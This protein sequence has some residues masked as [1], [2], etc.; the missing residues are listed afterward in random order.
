MANNY[1]IDYNDERFTNVEAEKNEQLESINN[2]YN[3][4]IDETD[5]T[6]KGLIDEINQNADKQAELQQQQGDLALEQIENRKEQAQKDYIKQQKGA[7]ADYQRQVAGNDVLMASQGLAHSGYSESSQVSMYNTYQSRVAIAKESIDRTMDD[8]AIQSKDAILQNS[9]ALMQIYSDAAKQKAA[10]TLEAF[11]YK[12]SLISELTN[13]ELAINSE[14]YGRWKDVENQINTENALAE[15]IRQYNEDLAEK[16]RQYNESMAYQKERDKIADEQWQKQYNLTKKSSSGGSGG[17]YGGINKDPEGG[18]KNDKPAEYY[19]SN[20]YQPRYIGEMKEENK[21]TPTGQKYLVN[22]KSQNI[23]QNKGKL[24]VWIGD[25]N[26][27]GYYKQIEGKTN[28]TIAKANNNTSSS[29]TVTNK[30]VLPWEE[31]NEN[32]PIWKR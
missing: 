24:Y 28:V 15:Q 12:N 23:W 8:F 1:E 26:K 11:Q 25:G 4:M 27:G 19:F 16:Q 2:R 29:K 13:K 22:G 6:Y 5:N 21:L 10:Y 17:S 31:Y 3:S 30:N 18:I 32:V 14:Y 9:V 7:Y 20:G